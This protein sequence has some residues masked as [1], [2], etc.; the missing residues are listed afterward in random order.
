MQASNVR[1]RWTKRLVAPGLLVAAMAMLAPAASA[2]V[3]HRAAGRFFGVMPRRGVAPASIRS[4]LA[5]QLARA[6]ASDNGNLDY[7]GGPVIH[8]SAPY[9]I[10]W[11]PSG[12]S[13][14][15]SSTSLL[16]RYFTDVTADTSG[17]D[18]LAV[19]RQYTDSSGFVDNR[20]VFDR[21]SQVIV[22]TDPYP[23]IDTA[24]C[25]RTDPTFYPECLTDAQLQSEVARLIAARGLPAGTGPDAPIYFVVTPSNVNVCLDGTDCADNTFCSYHSDFSDDGN[26]VLYAAIPFFLSANPSDTVQSPKG[27][28]RDGT[29]PVQEPNADLADVAISY[30]SHEYSETLTDPL[31]TGWWDSTSGNEAADNCVSS[32]ASDPATGS[33]PDAFAPTLGGDSSAGTLYDQLINGD[34]Y[35]TQAEWSNGQVGCTLR[36]SPATLIPAFTVSPA[37]SRPVDASLTFNAGATRATNPVS[38]VTWNFGDGTAPVF[39][40]GGAPLAPVSHAFAGAGRHTVTLTVVDADGNVATSTQQVLTGSPPTAR[41]TSSQARPLVLGHVRFSA[42]SSADPDAGVKVA[43]YAWSFGDGGSGAGVRVVHAYRRAGIYNVTLTVTNSLGLTA[44]TVHRVTIRLGLAR[45]TVHKSRHGA[46][47]LVSADGAGRVSVGRRTIRLRGPGTATFKVKLTAA[48]QRTLARRH[49]LTL[50]L[51]VHFAPVGG[52]AST[53]FVTV[54]FGR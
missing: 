37:G 21:S 23:A 22:D 10:F 33:S 44:R 42:A 16:E 41:F 17:D 46:T 48:Q 28:Q 34:R 43:S 9:L 2:V 40:A 53:T 52:K 49:K 38:S 30:M 20:R 50:P 54:R 29:S 39:R 18:A 32:G 5:A 13:L 4:S 14:P 31:G 7:H 26:D 36:P 3:I 6:A 27:C 25:P 15:A 11:T 12:D 1:H 51:R 19:D 47:V 24:N 8:S 35:Y 45:I